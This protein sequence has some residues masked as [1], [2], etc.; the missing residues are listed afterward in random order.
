MNVGTPLYMPLESLTKDVYS[1]KSDI[2]ALGIIVYKMLT[3]STP[4]KCET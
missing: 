1:F 2:F 3:G 4:W